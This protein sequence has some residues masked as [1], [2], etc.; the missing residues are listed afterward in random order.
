MPEVPPLTTEK[1][2]ASIKEIRRQK[3]EDAIA[4][5]KAELAMR[6]LAYSSRTSLSSNGSSESPEPMTPLDSPSLDHARV[7]TDAKESAVDGSVV[8]KTEST[9]VNFDDLASSFISETI[10]AAAVLPHSSPF[11]TST[12]TVSLEQP[13]N[14]PSS[15]VAAPIPIS[16]QTSA[17]FAPTTVTVPLT[18][19]Q[20]Q[21]KQKRW[22]ELVSTS[23]SLFGKIAAA[24]TK[25]EKDLLMRLLKAKTK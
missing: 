20:K 22:L 18:E 9:T 16:I 10:H 24:K 15:T 8:I 4:R 25:E 1:K 3:L 5:T 11:P 12:P 17:P 21:I 23:K 19:E 14:T 2:E 13:R 6:A 7:V